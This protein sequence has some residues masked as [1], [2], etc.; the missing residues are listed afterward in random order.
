MQIVNV[1]DQGQQENQ[2]GVPR[3]EKCKAFVN[4]FFDF[5]AGRKSFKCNICN[6]IQTAPQQYQD[7]YGD[8]SNTELCQ[9]SF[10]FYA[11]NQYTARTPKE[12]SYLFL[13]DISRSSVSCNIPFY[14]ISAIKELISTN[15]FNGGKSVSFAIAL[16][17]DQMHMAIFK[18]NGRLS[19]NTIPFKTEIDFIPNFVS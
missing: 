7:I 13:I 2:G 11:A 5:Q 8:Y 17:D 16:F 12:P 19:L 15:R 9:G 4:P 1:H 3:C 10:E 14:A 6:E 18:Q